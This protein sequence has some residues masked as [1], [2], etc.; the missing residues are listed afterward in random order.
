M[1][2]FLGFNQTG[3]NAIYREI[4]KLFNSKELLAKKAAPLEVADYIQLVLV[5]EMAICLIAEDMN[6]DFNRDYDQLCEIL[7]ESNEYGRI[8]NDCIEDEPINGVSF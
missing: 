4:L 5:P 3:M 1:D 2:G 7:E 8:V 6:Y